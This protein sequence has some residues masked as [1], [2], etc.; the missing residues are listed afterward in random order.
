MNK[1]INYCWPILSMDDIFDT[2]EGS[3]YFTKID[4]SGVSTS[5]EWLKKV[6]KLPR[7]LRL[8]DLLN[9]PDSFQSLMEQLLVGQSWSWKVTVPHLDNCIIYLFHSWRT[10]PKTKRSPRKIPL[11]ESKNEPDE[12]WIFPKSCHFSWSYHQQKWIRGRSIK[13]AAVEFSHSDEPDR[14]KVLP[15]HMFI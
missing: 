2:L 5:A 15:R 7:F 9:G 13:V 12:L 14:T 10:H 1:Q 11:C 8:S 3:E 4:M 6:Q